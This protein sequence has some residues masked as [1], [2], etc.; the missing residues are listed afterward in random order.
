M[1]RQCSFSTDSLFS[2]LSTQNMWFFYSENFSFLKL[3]RPVE[4]KFSERSQWNTMS[5]PFFYYLSAIL[6]GAHIPFPPFSR[7]EFRSCSSWPA[8]L[9]TSTQYAPFRASTWNRYNPVQSSAIQYNSV[10]SNTIQYNPV[11]S[12]T[13]QYNPVQSSAI[14][15]NQYNPIQSSTIQYT[16]VQ[17]SL[18]QFNPV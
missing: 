3:K 10:Q 7:I 8:L 6:Q 17:S 2:K 13:I 11:Q 16:P 12:S 9:A 18:I 1:D 15:Y 5:C 14:Q 4:F